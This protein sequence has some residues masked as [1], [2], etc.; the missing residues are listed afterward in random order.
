MTPR[1]CL[2]LAGFTLALTGCSL[3]GDLTPPPGVEAVRPANQPGATAAAPISVDAPLFLR[4]SAVDGAQV[5]AEH[6][7]ACHGETGNADGPM[8]AQVPEGYTVPKFNTPDR[9]RAASPQQWFATVTQGRLENFMPPFGEKLSPT[10]RWNVVA[11]LYALSTPPDVIAQGETLYA[12]NCASCH[13]P[14][15]QGDGPAA[16]GQTLADLSTTE[17][18]AAQTPEAL[19]T[20]LGAASPI[21]EHNF[22]AALPAADDRRAV[23]AYVQSLAY[24]YFAPGAP[25][26]ERTGAITG[27][28]VN[29]T[30][31]AALAEPLTVNLVGFDANVGVMTTLTATTDAAGQFAFNEVAYL[32]GAQFVVAADYRGI[33]YHSEPVGF[34]GQASLELPIRV[35]ETTEDPA[36]LRIDRVHT[37]LVFETPETVTVGQLYIF[38]NT[39]DKTFAP[40]NGRTVAFEVPAEATGLTVQDGEEGATWFRTE[41]GFEDTVPVVPGAG[42]SQVLYSY[43]LPYAGQLNFSQ[44]V[45][46]PAADVNVMVGDT[47]LTLSG[48][49]FVKTQAQDVQGM[50]FQNYARAGLAAG[51]ALTFALSG[52]VGAAAAAPA[53]LATSDSTGVWVGAGVFGVA[54]VGVGV[55]WWRMQKGAGRPKRDREDLLQALAE[56]D[57]EFAA[58]RVGQAEY[59]RDRRWLKDELA[60]IWEAGR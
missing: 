12:A 13:G 22:E 25:I 24:D 32:P 21:A 60:K 5:Y 55:W 17:F 36:A 20:A 16:A 45:L 43:R 8:T 48:E 9:A 3:A 35:Y 51:E 37:F 30:A 28:V 59:E 49:G 41:R 46:Y 54:L 47:T 31:G 15:G 11:Y 57:D 53:L 10:Q 2:A 29:G 19:F 38:S 7:A 58:G 14:A 56:L 39:G 33:T 34:E 27:R 23:A 4:A 1:T 6:C 50:P 44:T 42:T 26:P 18:F 52:S 40:A